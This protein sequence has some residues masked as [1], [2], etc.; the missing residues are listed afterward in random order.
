D[1]LDRLAGTA[2]YDSPDLTILRAA[3]ARRLGSYEQASEWLATLPA[4]LARRDAVP[5]AVEQA[6]LA[7]KLNRPVPALRAAERISPQAWSDPDRRDLV[8]FVREVLIVRA[9]LAAV[10]P[11][12]RCRRATRQEI[13]RNLAHLVAAKP[14]LAAIV[15]EA[16][17]PAI[18]CPL[19]AAADVELLIKAHQARRRGKGPLAASILEKLLA[20]KAADGS[21]RFL[22]VQRLADDLAEAG[23]LDRAVR[24]LLTQSDVPDD[25]RCHILARAGMLAW[26]AYQQHSDT[27]HRT[28]FIDAAGKLLAECDRSEQADRFKLLLAD[29]LSQTARFHEALQWLEQV[30]PGSDLFLEAKAVRVIIHTRQ[31]TDIAAQTPNPQATKLAERIRQATHDLMTLAAAGQ[32]SSEKLD[33]WTFDKRRLNLIGQALVECIRVLTHPAVGRRDEAD[34][35]QSTYQP[36]IER[37]QQQSTPARAVR[38]VMLCEKNDE[39]SLRRAMTLGEEL[40]DASELSGQ[41]KTRTLTTLLAAVHRH[42]LEHHAE[43][44]VTTA[45]ELAGQN[46]RLAQKAA[47][48]FAADAPLTTLRAIAAADAGDYAEFKKR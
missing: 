13:W 17:E 25:L 22:A 39:P 11:D 24:L 2:G 12:L 20:R 47:D 40:L 45:T 5:A 44:V 19:D 48:T 37:Y 15:F 7:L 16:I 8:R 23:Q 27:A 41:E 30:T 3:A 33:T 4:E 32:P 1:L 18:T 43:P 21:L 10:H 28:Q 9:K 36:L 42:R 14:R 31:F 35:L 26:Q 29:Q 38:I 6:E 46:R 34:T